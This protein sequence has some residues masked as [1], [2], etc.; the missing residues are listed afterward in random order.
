MPELP[1]VETLRR[2][3]GKVLIGKKIKK[4]ETKEKKMIA[5][6]SILKLN[7]VLVGRKIIDV[8]RRAKMLIM[9]LDDKNH[10]LVHL[11]MTGQLIYQPK[12]GQLVVG[13]H[14]QRGGLDNLPNKFTRVIF[15]F[16]DGTKLF[17]N[18]MRKFGWL[19]HTPGHKRESI[20]AKIG[21][22]PLE[23]SFTADFLFSILQRYPRRNIKQLLLDQ[24]LIAGLGNIYVDES[25]FASCIKPTRPAGLITKKEAEKLYQAIK[26]ILKLSI[27]KKGTSFRD[28]RRSDGKRGGFVPYLKVYGR[29]GQPC[30]VCGQKIEKTKIAGRGPPFFP[31]SPK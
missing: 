25:L 12:Q 10:I 6:L 18:D 27:Q 5:P 14:P 30:L 28:Y 11:K 8:N 7:K 1:E 15:D 9:D 16:S 26:N 31:N 23:K 4:I 29:G 19:R 3:L 17:F 2:E 24:T 20:F 21:P 22:E 13:G